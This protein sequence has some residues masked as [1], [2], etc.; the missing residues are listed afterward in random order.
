LSHSTTPILVK[1]FPRKG[2]TNHL[3]GLASSHDPPHLYLLI[4]RITSMSHR[5]P[6]VSPF[7]TAEKMKAW[8]SS[9][10]A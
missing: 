8:R 4:A 9:N 10:I 3:A 7:F 2:L 1:G 5:C 6:A